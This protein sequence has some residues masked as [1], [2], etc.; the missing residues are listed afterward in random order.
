MADNSITINTEQ[1]FGT[2]NKNSLEAK[3]VSLVRSC[4][5]DIATSVFAT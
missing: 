4:R 5:D 1:S 3:N 2:F